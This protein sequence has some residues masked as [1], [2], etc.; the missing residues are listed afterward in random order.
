[1]SCVKVPTIALPS[2]SIPGLT[3]GASITLPVPS[4]PNICCTYE[5]PNPI[6]KFLEQKALSATLSVI[7][8]AAMV[9]ALI[10]LTTSIDVINVYLDTIPPVCPRE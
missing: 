4:I 10:L 1:M 8:T 2:L 6:A 3:L 7:P 5:I 9:P